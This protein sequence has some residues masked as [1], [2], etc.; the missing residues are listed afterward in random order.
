MPTAARNEPLEQEIQR[1]IASLQRL[2]EAFGERRAQLAREAGI[3]ETQ[4]RL[5]ESVEDEAFL[6]SLF[7]RRRACTPAAVSQTL[8]QLLDAGLVH[9]RIG[10]DDARQRIYALTPRGRRVLRRLRD[11]RTRAIAAIWR[12]LHARPLRAFVRFADELAERL[13][14]YAGRE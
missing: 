10:E 7:A 11:S 8:R 2:S 12:P 1:A 6:P 5:L 14:R 4:W 9:V 3:T 13:E